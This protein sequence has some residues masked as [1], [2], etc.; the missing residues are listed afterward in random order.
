M[1]LLIIVHCACVFYMTGVIWLVQL[2]HYPLMRFVPVDQFVEFHAQ[3]SSLIT[4]VV[5]PV[6]LAQL[7]TCLFLPGKWLWLCG[8]L[9][10]AVFAATFF[11]SVPFHNSLT[12][13]F[14]ADVHQALVRT[15]WI[16]TALWSAHSLVL[17][18]FLVD[19]K[20]S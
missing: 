6:M 1:S 15:N 5:G 13:G 14:N 10:L 16:R 19:T 20:G 11:V 3:H 2:V 4:F 12:N 17:I 7:A 8:F 9:S 18:A